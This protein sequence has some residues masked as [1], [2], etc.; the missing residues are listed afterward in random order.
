[1][2]IPF[3]KRDQAN[4]PKKLALFSEEKKQYFINVLSAH[5]DAYKLNYGVCMR[6]AAEA[7]KDGKL[8]QDKQTELTAR[9]VSA[10]VHSWEMPEEFGECNR[11]S[12]FKLLLDY[13]QIRDAVDTFA[14]DDKRY[15]EKK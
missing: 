14:N 12:A 7:M 2:A 15:I 8:D 13:P 5:S 4:T 10:A 11:E 1:M 3:L 6:E 9:L